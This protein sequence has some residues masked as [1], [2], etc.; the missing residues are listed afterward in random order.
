M[1][2]GLAQGMPHAHPTEISPRLAPHPPATALYYTA[3]LRFASASPTPHRLIFLPPS[4]LSHPPVH[5]PVLPYIPNPALNINPTSTQHRQS[6]TQRVLQQKA[7]WAVFHRPASAVGLQPALAG[8][9]D[10]PRQA[11]SPPAGTLRVAGP[12]PSALSR[13]IL[14]YTPS[15]AHA[16]PWQPPTDR[17]RRLGGRFRA[18]GRSAHASGVGGGVGGV[19]Y[20]TPTPAPR[21]ARR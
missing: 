15:A 17:R 11:S 1:A 16:A 20:P 7:G 4:P 10:P 21:H 19:P 2:C 18:T 12:G 13:H 6:T 3:A 9:F 8:C 5:H 14:V